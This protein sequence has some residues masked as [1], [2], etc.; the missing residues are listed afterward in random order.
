MDQPPLNSA[1]PPVLDYKH[2]PDFTRLIVEDLPDGVRVT[3]PGSRKFTALFAATVISL[4]VAFLSHNWVASVTRNQLLQIGATV[5]GIV[6]A[7][8]I[9]VATLWRTRQ[10]TILTLAPGKFVFDW[11][12]PLWREKVEIPLDQVRGFTVWLMSMSTSIDF[13]TLGALSLSTRDKIYYMFRYT[14]VDELKWLAHFLT[15]RASLADGLVQISN[16]AIS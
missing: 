2:R 3:E 1:V 14:P 7:L 9:F 16:Q 12:L 15:H 11:P 6:L 8:A 13:R 4:G 5:L 10:A